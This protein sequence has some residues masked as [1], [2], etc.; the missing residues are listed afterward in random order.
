MIRV[1]IDARTRSDGT[2]R[3]RSEAVLEQLGGGCTAARFARMG[4]A[5]RKKRQKEWMAHVKYNGRWN[6]ELVF[7][8]LCTPIRC[9][10]GLRQTCRSIQAADRQF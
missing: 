5:E 1:R 10:N 9:P 3:A 4:R 7:E 2:D 6:V 8:P